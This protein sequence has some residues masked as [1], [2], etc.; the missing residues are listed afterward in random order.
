M[1]PARGYI[2]RNR[3]IVGT[4][5]LLVTAPKSMEDQL[6]SGTWTVIRYARIRKL[7]TVALH[8]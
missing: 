5:D 8:P 7:T 1:R 2:A 4:C 6:G 3:D